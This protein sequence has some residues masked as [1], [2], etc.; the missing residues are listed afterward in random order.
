MAKKRNILSNV[1]RELYEEPKATAI[2]CIQPAQ[3][4][5]TH[6]MRA[7]DLAIDE[8]QCLLDRELLSVNGWLCPDG[9]LYACSWMQHS[10]CLLKLGYKNEREAVQNGYIRLTEMKWKLE[11]FEKERQSITG[12]QLSTIIEWHRK[13]SL[14]K[15]Y[16][17]YCK[18]YG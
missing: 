8:N 7:F 6:A 2:A 13:N 5:A 9:N 12:K 16:F 3:P 17:E 4:K 18:K 10:E 15:H 14:E 11:T 1:F